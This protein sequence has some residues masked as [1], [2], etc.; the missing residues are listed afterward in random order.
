MPAEPQ[1]RCAFGRRA[2][3]RSR[4]GAAAPSALRG[5][6]AR[7]AAS[8]RRDRRR[9]AA[10]GA[11][12]ARSRPATYSLASLR[13]RRDPR[14]L[15][16]I[17]G[18]VGEQRA[19]VLDRRAAARRRDDDRLQPVAVDLAHPGV[20]VGAHLRRAPAPRGPCDAASEPQQPS[21]LRQHDVDAGAVEQTDRRGVDLAA[22][23][24]PARSRSAARRGGARRRDGRA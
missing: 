8:R 2:H 17:G 14:R 11:A 23:A 20:D 24:R 6:S 15:V 4:R 22:P 21:P 3:R 13:Q 18:I 5:S 10:C 1:H 9:R 12:K 7:A 16:G 19:V